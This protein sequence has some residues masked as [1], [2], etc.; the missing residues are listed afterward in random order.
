[1]Y[2]PTT[3]SDHSKGGGGEGGGGGNLNSG[4]S[5]SSSGNTISDVGGLHNAEGNAK[6]T[7][8][9]EGVGV[10]TKGDGGHF[11]ASSN[12]DDVTGDEVYGIK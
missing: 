4:K 8:Y 7:A 9:G 1:M 10:P 11:N 6:A 2:I 3:R 5:D 12:D